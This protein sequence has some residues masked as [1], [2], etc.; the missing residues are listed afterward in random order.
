[1]TCLDTNYDVCATK[2]QVSRST[3]LLEIASVKDQR[4][5]LCAVPA[6]RSNVL[7]ETLPAKFDLCC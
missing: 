3:G 7:L 6:V 2:P 1:M 4:P 5:E